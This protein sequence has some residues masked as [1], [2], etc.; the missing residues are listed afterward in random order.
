MANYF[1]LI[2]F[3]LIL[4]TSSKLNNEDNY[5]IIIDILV[6]VMGE[7]GFLSPLL[8]ETNLSNPENYFDLEEFVLSYYPCFTYLFVLIP[9]QR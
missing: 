5:N 3:I 1:I 2:F 6:D 8:L 4:N 9:M 7:P